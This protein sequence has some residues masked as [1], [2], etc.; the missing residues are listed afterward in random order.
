MRVK[1][2]VL[3]P[4]SRNLDVE[5]VEIEGEKLKPSRIV[6]ELVK[7]LGGKLPIRD[8]GIPKPGYIVLLDGVDL[9][10]LVEEDEVLEK[11][12]VKLTIIPVNHGG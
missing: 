12:E 9:R 8:D 7:R 11:D 6:G 1:L 4:L 5:S 2:E 3:P 10:I